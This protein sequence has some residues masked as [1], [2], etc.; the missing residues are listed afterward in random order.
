M[1]EGLKIPAAEREPH[2]ARFPRLREQ[3]IAGVLA[4]V[5][6]SALTG[7]P[8]Q[9]LPNHASFVIGGIDGNELLMHLDVAGFGVSSGSACKTGDPEPSEVLL[10]LDLPRASALGSLRFTVALPTSEE[11]VTRLLGALPGIVKKMQAAALLGVA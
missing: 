4:G 9:R 7:H 8:S 1:A 5:P 11:H 3:L 2:N 6:E 10:A